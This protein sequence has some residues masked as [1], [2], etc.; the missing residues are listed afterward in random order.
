MRWIASFNSNATHLCVH[1]RRCRCNSR[2]RF[3]LD[4]TL[5]PRGLARRA[6]DAQT[7]G[8]MPPQGDV[9]LPTPNGWRGTRPETSPMRLMGSESPTRWPECHQHAVRGST[10]S[11]PEATRTR[12]IRTTSSPGPTGEVWEAFPPRR[13]CAEGLRAVRRQVSTRAERQRE[14]YPGT[15]PQ[16]RRRDAR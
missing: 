12:R 16:D 3:S 11:G 6:K 5:E 14:R 9:I 10:A 13:S 2:P 7:M 1:A 4:G 8:A 15:A